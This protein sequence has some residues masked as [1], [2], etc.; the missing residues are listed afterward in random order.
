ME[1][2]EFNPSGEVWMEWE[3]AEKLSENVE[4]QRGTITVGCGTFLTIV[5]CS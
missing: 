3:E 5:C 2:K 1:Q 4:V